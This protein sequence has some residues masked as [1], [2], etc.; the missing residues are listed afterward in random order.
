MILSS[1]AAPLMANAQ[2]AGGSAAARQY[3]ELR[4][5]YLRNGSHAPRMMDLLKN[6]WAPAAQRLGGAPAG[7][8]QPLIGEQ[9]PSVLMVSAYASPDEAASAFDR[10]MQHEDFAAAYAQ[11]NTPE[12]A[13]THMEATLLR[14]FEGLPA[15]TPPPARANGSHIFELRTYESNTMASLRTK[16]AMFNGGEIGIFQRLGMM[17]VFFG[18]AI[19]GHNLPHLTYMLTYE[20]LAARE[21]VWKEF[22]ADAEFTRLRSKPGYA[23]ADIV[24]TISNSLL[25]PLSFSQIR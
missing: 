6:H 3:I 11:A 14:A 4:W 12:P 20:D 13:F 2:T 21:R 25:N 16:L 22:I 8:F 19:F 17:P 7:F 23:D 24:S 1:L 18:E 15:L 5:F 9:S 10:M